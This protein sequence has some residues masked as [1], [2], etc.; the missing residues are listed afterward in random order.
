MGQILAILDTDAK[1]IGVLYARSR[2]GLIGAVLERHECGRRLAEK[3]ETM[4]HGEWG[5]WVERNRAHLGFGEETARRLIVAYQNNPSLTRD[6][7]EE[8]AKAISRKMWGNEEKSKLPSVRPKPG[9]IIVTDDEDP[10][11]EEPSASTL[12]EDMRIRGLLARAAQAKEWAE[13]DDMAGIETTEEMREAV[14]ETAR[15]WINLLSKLEG[16]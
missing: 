3:K 8:Q 2:A 15:A 12:P 7:T 10:D 6:L 1:E 13:A 9:S 16:E 5:E 4:R 11:Y 14:S